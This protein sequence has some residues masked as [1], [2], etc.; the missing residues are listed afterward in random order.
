M[1]GLRV[2][3]CVYLQECWF[4]RLVQRVVVVRSLFEL[5]GGNV[6]GQ[7]LIGARSQVHGLIES[8]AG[9]GVEVTHFDQ[10]S[11]W[12]NREIRRDRDVPDGNPLLAVTVPD[13]EACTALASILREYRA[14][15]RS[16]ELELHLWALRV[17][18]PGD[19]HGVAEL[20]D[21]AF[22]L[23]R[24]D[25]GESLALAGFR[26]ESPDDLHAGAGG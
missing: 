24:L 20:E 16:R 15:R 25:L 17:R 8:A 22:A 14:S 5:Q 23:A 19:I 18:P 9:I 26:G 7:R 10:R 4:T 1:E 3:Q 2:S 12:R 11:G 6:V 13:S 21:H